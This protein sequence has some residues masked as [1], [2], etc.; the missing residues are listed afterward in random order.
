MYVVDK[1]EIPPRWTGVVLVQLLSVEDARMY[2]E[3][4]Y[5]TSAIANPAMARGLTK[6]LGIEIPV[7]QTRVEIKPGDAMIAFLPAEGAEGIGETE[8]NGSPLRIMKFFKT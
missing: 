8:R 7:N 4:K 5:W 3:G 2:L 6:L 1:N